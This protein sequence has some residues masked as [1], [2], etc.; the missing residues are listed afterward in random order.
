VER[1]ER[2]RIHSDVTKFEYA[3]SD[4]KWQNNKFLGVDIRNQIQYFDPISP[5]QKRNNDANLSTCQ[6]SPK[7]DFLISRMSHTK[8]ALIDQKTGILNKYFILE[9]KE[10]EKPQIQKFC[11]SNDGANVIAQTKDFLYVYDVS[12]SSSALGFDPISLKCIPPISTVSILIMS[13]KGV[14]ITGHEEG[15]LLF[16]NE[17]TM[18]KNSMDKEHT[19]KITALAF[20]VKEEVLASGDLNGTVFFW[21]KNM[22]KIPEKEIKNEGDGNIIKFFLFSKL[23]NGILFVLYNFQLETYNFQKNVGE[24]LDFQ[25]GKEYGDS[26]SL[27]I[28]SNDE[29]FIFINVRE[30]EILILKKINEKYSI[31]R[32]LQDIHI[33]GGVLEVR[34]HPLE[35]N[36]FICK[37]AQ[38]IYEVKNIVEKLTI[39]VKGKVYRIRDNIIISDPTDGKTQKISL[40]MIS[41]KTGHQLAKKLTKISSIIVNSCY[42]LMRNI[43]FLRLL[44]NIGFGILKKEF[45]WKISKKKRKDG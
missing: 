26:P 32:R 21:D 13:R 17:K 22:K 23:K 31:A 16:F 37:G 39:E 40:Q 3:F 15:E 41:S 9:N 29:N 10:E 35:K 7:E 1:K 4:F 18:K 25:F 2:R 33:Y 45:Q 6:Y 14:I 44:K 28:I 11:F 8:I 24:K 12:G 38:A 30:I 43:Y 36:N 42:Q 34:P 5:I 19:A 20:D 27:M